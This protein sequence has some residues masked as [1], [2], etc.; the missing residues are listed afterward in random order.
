MGFP[1]DAIAVFTVVV[2]LHIVDKL[3]NVVV[4]L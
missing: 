2:L 1:V 4:L 3:V